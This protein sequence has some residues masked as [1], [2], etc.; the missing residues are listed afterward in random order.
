VK[1]VSPGT[2]SNY[3]Q[4]QLQEEFGPSLGLSTATARIYTIPKP[5][6]VNSWIVT[7]SEALI[8]ARSDTGS[9]R[10]VQKP[11]RMTLELTLRA[12]ARRKFGWPPTLQ[13]EDST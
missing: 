4:L 3:P 2:E 10:K 8:L 1:A 6:Q 7:P 11:P 5:L 9:V 12:D 13:P